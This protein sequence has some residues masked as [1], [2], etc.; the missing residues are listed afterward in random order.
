MPLS[1]K[2]IRSQLQL[3]RPFVEGCSPELLRRGQ[4][5][6]GE[7][8]EAKYREAVVSRDHD[9]SAFS[10]AH[11]DKKLLHPIQLNTLPS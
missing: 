5:K 10:G 2:Q 9:F 6:V 8:M 4:N 7:W 11:G 1:A 3:L